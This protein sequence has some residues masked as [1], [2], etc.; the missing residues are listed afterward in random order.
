MAKKQKSPYRIIW[1]A[2]ILILLIISLGFT[3]WIVKLLWLKQLGYQD[4]FWTIK[5][6]QIGL[7]VS[8]FVISV[9]FIGINLRI[10][11]KH[12]RKLDLMTTP[13]SKLQMNLN[14]PM[15]HKAL[16]LL[17]WIFAIALG[18]LFAFA[19]YY[20]W[21]TFFRFGWHQ[22]FGQLDP[23]FHKDIG[24]YL[25]RLPFL[26]LLQNGLITLS[27]IS[28]VILIVGYFYLGLLRYQKG[29][30]F[31]SPK[32]VTRHMTVNVSIWLLF[33]SWGFY[34]DRYELLY[35][36]GSVVFGAGFTDVHV[37][38]PVLWVLIVLTL[39]LIVL[40][41]L[42]G[43]TNQMKRIVTTAVVFIAVIAV[44]QFILPALVQKYY[45]EP[46]E[47]K[48]QT[49]YLK[50]NIKFTRLAYKLNDIKEK[51][52][53]AE[54]TL[55]MKQIQQNEATISNIRLWDPRLL[56]QTYRQLQEIRLYYQFY[57][58]DVDRYH[59]EKG[60]REMMLSA[61]ELAQSLPAKA[62]T[63]VNKH[64]QYTHGYGLV[65]SPVAEKGSEGIPKLV[66]KN[67]PPEAEEGLKVN[68][69]AIYY[70]EKEFGYKIV[71][72]NVKELDYPK[73]SNNV[74]THYNGN[75]GIPLKGFWR[76]SLFAWYKGD[77]NL[78]LSGYLTPQSR[79]QLFRSVKQRVE[80]IAPFLHYDNDP[81]LVLSDSGKLYWIQDAY[82]ESSNFP[83]SESYQGEFNYIRNSVKVVIDAFNG[84]VNFY[85]VNKEDPVLKVYEKVFPEIFKPLSAM[86]ASL[87][88]HIRY[89][90]YLFKIQMA[91]YNTYHMTNPQVFYNNEDLWTRP[92]EKYGGMSIEMQPYYVLA[93]LPD[94]NRLQ[95]MLISPLTPSKRDNMIAWM[96]AKCDA[97]DY[98]DVIVYQLP[99]ERLIYGPSQIEAQIDQN[100]T[101]SQQL[102]LWDQKGSKV[103]RGNLMVIPID[104]TFIY[105]EPVF[106]I[107]EGV[108]I[109]QLQRV[110]VAYGDQIAMEPTLK[111]AI[112][113]IFGS[114]AQTPPEQPPPQT[115]SN[116]LPAQNKIPMP[117]FNRARELWKEAQQALKS[118]NWA[119]FGQK[120][121]QLK[122]ILEPAASKDTTKK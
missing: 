72:T 90:E 77:I 122:Q 59:T 22:T 115:I 1:L 35:N 19:F 105:V 120:M 3:D 104:N 21:D 113:D 51:K 57:S 108:E 65:M 39:I 10:L 54:D 52:Y 98:G 100:T 14:S 93:K 31:T 17:L 106:L 46:N 82:T 63:W 118:D 47:L 25:F 80:E 50:N 111:G 43:F 87:R 60:Y 67:L 68:Q 78:L 116:Q 76:R 41:L 85:V 64:L 12:M 73:G 70:G 62:N 55:T 121:N 91:K 8:A 83:Y 23:I 114:G 117:E 75:G 5:F 89:P 27:F 119:L 4:V 40:V 110:I 34:L 94:E 69:P 29:S 9:L 2:I 49:P 101:I 96:A 79:I 107:A 88:Q 112:D 28:S 84:S 11:A 32:A 97:P 26:Q 38:L 103:I 20:Q 102:S 71:N 99:K 92:T 16:G 13:L 18:L 58:V 24:F 45:V 33:L 7:M 6:A 53:S 37:N 109:P 61:R 56:I 42:Q 86:P 44:G 15:A 30:G 95:Y 81:Y 36:P 48:L 74:Y 66:I